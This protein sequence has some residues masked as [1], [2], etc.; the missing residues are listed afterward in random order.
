MAIG[1]VVVQWVWERWVPWHEALFLR[2]GGSPKQL[3]ALVIAVIVV[4]LATVLAGRLS[5]AWL[6]VTTGVFVLGAPVLYAL[7]P[8]LTF[9]GPG[10]F[11]SYNSF[12]TDWNQGI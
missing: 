6:L 4:A 9:D 3:V 10:G 12:W 8:A 7:I 5:W 11:S 1:F 2:Y